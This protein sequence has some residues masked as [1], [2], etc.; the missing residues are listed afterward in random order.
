MSTAGKI[1]LLWDPLGFTKTLSPESLA[2]KRV[3]E[4]KNG[5]ARARKLP[6]VA[7]QRA[8]QQAG[9]SPAALEPRRCVSPARAPREHT[10]RRALARVCLSRLAMIGAMSLVSAHF[11]KDSVPLLP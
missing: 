7:F 1:P 2:R 10:A 9:A 5:C 8:H 4:L 6:P 3:A 11:I